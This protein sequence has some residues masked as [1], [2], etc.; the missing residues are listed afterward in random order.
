MRVNHKKGQFQIHKHGSFKCHMLCCDGRVDRS[1]L[2][3]CYNTPEEKPSECDCG[4]MILRMVTIHV[5]KQSDIGWRWD[6][7]QVKRD[8]TFAMRVKTGR[9]LGLLTRMRR[10]FPS[11][12]I[13]MV[14]SKGQEHY[15]RLLC[16]SSLTK[17]S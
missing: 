6:L 3:M 9:V 14:T 8:H 12:V 4:I 10:E 16:C 13:Y 5:P 15:E 17:T 1:M 2:Q 7:Y 11:F